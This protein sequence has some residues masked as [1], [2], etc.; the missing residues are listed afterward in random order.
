MGTDLHTFITGQLVVKLREDVT[1][2]RV[3]NRADLAHAAY[4]HVRRYLLIQPGW[5]C[6]AETSTP[7][8]TADLAL[9]RQERFVALLRMECLLKPGLDDFFPADMLEREMEKL[10]RSR[11]ALEKSGPGGAYLLGV[12]DSADAWFYPSEGEEP[13]R[14]RAGSAAGAMREE[15][16]CFWVPLNMRE[17]P[18]HAEWRQKW[19]RMAEL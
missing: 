8:G 19:A 16:T 17:L 15:Q 3:A 6:R 1:L 2:L 4:F 18:N 12:Y 10:R 14:Y 5:A 7:E 9:F 11:A 13:G